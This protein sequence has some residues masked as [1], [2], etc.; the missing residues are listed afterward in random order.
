MVTVKVADQIGIKYLVNYL[1]RF[2][3]RRRFA[4]H[5]SIALGSAEVTPLE[6]AFAYSTLAN[7]GLRPEP[8][9]VTE[10]TDPQ[11]RVI[12]TNTPKLTESIPPTTA[13]L[14]TSILQ[15]VVRRG[16]GRGARGLGRPTAGKTGTTNDLHDTWFVGFTRQLLTAVWVGFD[17][18]RS[19]G[20]YETGG[21]VAA[22]IWKAF[23]EEATKDHPREDFP[24]PDG[25]KCVQ[26]DPLTGQRAIPGGE[27]ILECFREGSQ[28]QLGQIPAFQAVGGE[29]PPAPSALDFLR[30]DF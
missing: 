12:E 21:R 28:P 15:D 14:V 25:L 13:Y 4:P 20:R 8:I 27:A 11:G 24:V 22:P 18:K 7:G 26:I 5:L 9:I 16:T 6:L 1:P 29:G 17:S 19:L 3:F 23:M 30:S 10:I 2:G